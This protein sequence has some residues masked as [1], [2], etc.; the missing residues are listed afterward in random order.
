VGGSVVGIAVSVGVVV[1]EGLGS[2]VGDE[3]AAS[4]GLG[5]AVK[6]GS[7]IGVAE[8]VAPA[9]GVGVIKPSG[10]HTC[11]VTSSTYMA[12]TPPWPSL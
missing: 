7:E 4:E 2:G 5:V 10:P 6:L 1:A 9:V 12:V 8:G 3:L 11:T